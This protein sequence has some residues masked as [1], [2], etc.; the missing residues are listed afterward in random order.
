VGEQ[1][2]ADDPRTRSDDEL[3][4]ALLDGDERR[5]AEI[6]DAWS[7]AMLRLARLHVSSGSAAEDVLQETWMAVLGGLHRFEGRARLRTWVFQ[8][9]LNVARTQG[10]KDRRT[11]PFSALTADLDAGPTV[12]PARFQGPQEPFPGG[13]RQFPA[14]WTSPE[15]AALSGEAERVIR[16]A[17]MQLP[18]RQRVV[19]AL[20]DVDGCKPQEVCEILGLSPGNQRV[21]LHRACAFV[22][23]QVEG[24]FSRRHAARTERT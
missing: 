14:P 8:I 15:D 6:V 10:V 13:W 3:V 4:A 7:P 11:V 23:Q 9:L 1:A 5:F 22:R 17:I 16:E 2:G 12:D 21:L 19:I 18:E 24:Y 20:R